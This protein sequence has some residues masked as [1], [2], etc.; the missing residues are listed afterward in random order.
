MHNIEDQFDILIDAISGL[1]KNTCVERMNNAS[2]A[3]KELLLWI[4]YLK[5]LFP[6]S[7]ALDLLEGTR[8]SMLESVAY[9]GLGLGRAAIGATRTQID[10]MLGFTY[11]YDHPREWEVVKNVGEGFQLRSDIDKY[12]KDKRKRFKTN[13]G[14]IEGSEDLSLLKV[15]RILSAHIHAQ[16]PSTIPKAG[17][18]GD[19][20]SSDSFIKSLIEIQDKSVRCLSNYLTAI[21]ISDDINPPFEV[22][23]RIKAQLTP[24]QRRLIFFPD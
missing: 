6:N 9:I 3:C 5:C 10:L 24:K 7:C 17:E 19:L 16:S 21:F 4:D 15:Y 14:L 1:E 8:A 12:H 11:F 13:I 18:F 20:F 22:G 2:T 23:I